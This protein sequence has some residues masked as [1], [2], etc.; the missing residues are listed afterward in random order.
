M[1]VVVLSLFKTGQTAGATCRPTKHDMTL[2]LLRQ[3]IEPPEKCLD[4]GVLDESGSILL[5]PSADLSNPCIGTGKEVLIKG[6][7]KL[8]LRDCESIA[9]AFPI[10]PQRSEAGFWCYRRFNVRNIED[11]FR[12]WTGNSLICIHVLRITC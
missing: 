10:R 12:R 7:K 9:T 11:E 6:S 2:Q 3:L 8:L 1:S 4:I 5:Q